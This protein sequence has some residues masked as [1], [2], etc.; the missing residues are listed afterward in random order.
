MK[1]ELLELLQF[2]KN[3]VSVG[4]DER[5]MQCRECREKY[6]VEGLCKHTTCTWVTRLYVQFQGMIQ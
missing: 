1:E 4:D 5:N 6:V 3:I 2:S